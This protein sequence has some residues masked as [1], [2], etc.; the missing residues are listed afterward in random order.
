MYRDTN[1]AEDLD[2]L[3]TRTKQLLLLA[4]IRERSGNLQSSLA[5][6]TEARDNQYRVQQ[7]TSLEQS[8]GAP[9]QQKMMAKYEIVLSIFRCGIYLFNNLQDMLCHGRAGQQLAQP[10]ASH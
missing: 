10:S 7:R 4:R 1:D 3:Q 6:L 2:R 8:G 9:E 5:T